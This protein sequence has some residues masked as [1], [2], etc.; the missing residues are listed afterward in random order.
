MDFRQLEYFCAISKLENFTRTAEYLHVSQPSVTKAIKALESELKLT[1]IDRRQKH[2]TLT[3]EGKAFLLHAEKIMKDVEDTKNDMA[4]FQ[5]EKLG[6]VHFGIPPMVE[7]YLF[8]DLFTSFKDM[9][10]NMSLDVK[11]YSDSTEV[12]QKAD[13]GELDFGIIF[14]DELTDRDHEMLIQTDNLSLCVS[15]ELELAK[16]NQIEFDD[17]RNE[18]FIMQQSNTYQYQHVYERCVERGFVP[19]ILLCTTQ[20]KTIKQLVANRLGISVLPD[21]VTREETK[22]VRRQLTPPL[23]VHICLYWGKDK[24]LTDRDERFLNFMKQY[25][26]S[27]DFTKNFQPVETD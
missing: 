2:V 8:P 7:A 19:N 12:L 20:L 26:A 1:L 4:R 23:T 22:F 24:E 27:E 16:R 21:F 15:P 17:L 6:T 13:K 14:T 11:E 25:I 18:Q 3:K 10:P 9:Y 5:Q